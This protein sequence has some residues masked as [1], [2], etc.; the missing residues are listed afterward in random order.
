MSNLLITGASGFV[1]TALI[2]K[3]LEKGHKVYGF[4]RHPPAEADN[5]FPLIGD[6]TLPNLGLTPI[7]IKLPDFDAVYHL[8]GIHR[9]GE[10]R[11]GTIWKTNVTGTKNVLDFC[12]K[13]HIPRL[14]FTSTAYTLGRNPY[15][16]SKVRNELDIEA[17]RRKHK[18]KV[19]IFKPSVVMETEEHPYPGHF[20]QF[21][22]LV[23]KIHQS[24]ELVRRKIEGTLRLPVIE[25]VFR[26]KGNPEG[27]LNLVTVD[28]VV[29]AMANVDKEG[30]FWLTNPNPPS[31]GELVEWAGELIMVRMRIEPNF[32]PTPIES[33]FAKIAQA[34][35][36][37]LWGDDFP[38]H[39]NDCPP[40]TKEFIQ[41]T[42]KRTILG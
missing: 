23:V 29:E 2:E 36:P 28:A 38:S 10:D 37:Y 16:L 40:I 4:S 12:V 6:I 9:L 41:S 26:I 1:G 42:I 22:A 27:R 18:L 17:T 13:H 15:E 25:P 21:I 20:S 33:Q 8:A 39:L 32:K 34:F 5:L 11:D 24:A 7:Y 30:T 35:T 31:L 3:L 14:Y 19:T